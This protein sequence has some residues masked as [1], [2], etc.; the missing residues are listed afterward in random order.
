[1]T[2]CQVC[3]GRDV[4]EEFLAAGIWPLSAGW[5]PRGFERKRFVGMEY[6]LTSPVFGLRR[7]EGSSDEVIVAELEPEAS[8]I[9]GPWNRK[10]YLSLVEVCKRNLRLNRWLAEM[11]VEYGLRPVP[12]GAVP[13][14]TPPGNVGSEVASKK[15]KGK[16][17]KEEVGTSGEGGGGGGRSHGMGRKPSSSKASVARAESTKR[18]ARD[19]EVSWGDS[20]TPSFMEELMG[21]MGGEIVVPEVRLFRS[22]YD[23]SD[24][25]RPCFLVPAVGLRWRKH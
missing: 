5:A 14:M 18:K 13:R 19:E 21:T 16:A 9:L 15:S 3:G 22:R 10:E 6:D 1:M 2:A 4:V 8:D 12:A 7:P 20:G 11:G 25:Y 24:E 23:L 17:K